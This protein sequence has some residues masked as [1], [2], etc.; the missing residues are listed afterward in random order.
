MRERHENREILVINGP[1][2]PKPT[3][4]WDDVLC[5]TCAKQRGSLYESGKRSRGTT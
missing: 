4:S 5:A 1:N 3:V 2:L